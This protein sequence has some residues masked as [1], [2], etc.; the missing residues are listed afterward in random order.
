MGFGPIPEGARN[1]RY[2]EA[3]AFSASRKQPRHIPGPLLD[4]QH[5]YLETMFSRLRE[6]IIG[7]LLRATNWFGDDPSRV[8]TEQ[9]R[10][11]SCPH[12]RRQGPGCMRKGVHPTIY[13]QHRAFV[14]GPL[15]GRCWV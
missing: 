13:V 12:L 4:N 7:E 6:G 1:N 5:P 9:A 10:D 2:L 15:L 11:A 8:K 3:G 14:G